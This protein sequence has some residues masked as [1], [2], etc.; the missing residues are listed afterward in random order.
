MSSERHCEKRRT[1]EGLAY[2]LRSPGHAD[3]ENKI[4]DD[5][6]RASDEYKAKSL[7]R[8]TLTFRV[9]RLHNPFPMT[10]GHSDRWPTRLAVQHSVSS[11]PAA[12]ELRVLH[13]QRLAFDTQWGSSHKAFGPLYHRRLQTRCTRFGQFKLGTVPVKTQK[14]ITIIYAMYHALTHKHMATAKRSTRFLAT[15]S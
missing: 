12:A 1:R 8:V 11:T 10:S 13:H 5:K 2:L 4:K 15:D 7:L 3:N 14:R 6:T 9:W